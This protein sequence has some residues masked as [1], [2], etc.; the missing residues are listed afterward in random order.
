VTL[1]VV[2]IPYFEF[3]A[4]APQDASRPAGPGVH[5]VWKGT[6]R[7]VPAPPWLGERACWCCHATPLSV[8]GPWCSSCAREF[9]G[10]EVFAPRVLAARGIVAMRRRAGP[11]T[12]PRR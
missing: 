1:A 5:V 3:V 6:W 10:D 12:R 4:A 7:F 11:P 8:W 9:L 2:E